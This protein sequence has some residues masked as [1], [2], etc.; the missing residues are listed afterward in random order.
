[1]NLKT[2]VGGKDRKH[3]G[4]RIYKS[5]TQIISDIPVHT[6]ELWKHLKSI[7]NEVVQ[8][9]YIQVSRLIGV[10]C[11]KAL[12]P[13]KII[14]SESGGPYTYKTKLGWCFVGSLNCITEG[15]TTS[16]N[17]LAIKN[18]ALSK[19]ESHHFP[20]EKAVKDVSL[21]KYFKQYFSMIL[22]NQNLSEL[23]PC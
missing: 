18:V 22:V 21:G 20:T 1:M 23:V 15:I 9:D 8:K 10:N 17:R 5:D 19:I 6:E 7:S 2:L 3:H 11:M 14:H 13:T 4:C 12:E 16:R